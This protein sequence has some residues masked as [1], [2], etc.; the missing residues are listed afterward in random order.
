MNQ[1]ILNKRAC[2]LAVSLLESDINYLDIASELWKIGNGI[3][4]EGWDTEFHIFGVI[5][6]ETD[7]LPLNRVRQHC[8]SKMLEKTDKELAETIVF[9]KAQVT[10][11]CNA[12]LA[13]FKN[14]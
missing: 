11:A 12:I 13:K 8:S 10:E 3:Y 14:V 5:G 2:E 6:T 4:S 9:Y 7:H 1:E